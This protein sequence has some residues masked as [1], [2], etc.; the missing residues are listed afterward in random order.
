VSEDIFGVLFSSLRWTTDNRGVFYATYTGALENV[1]DAV[2]K[3]DERAN[4]DAKINNELDF[5]RF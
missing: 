1:N 5:A 2:S 3:D 4:E